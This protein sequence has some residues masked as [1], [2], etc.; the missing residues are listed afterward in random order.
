[1][2]RLWLKIAISAGLIAWFLS[3]T[4]I[5][6]VL[7]QLGNLGAGAV[8]AGAT[9]SV[10]AWLV[11]AFR[12]WL[13]VPEFQLR[14]VIRTSFI[15]LFYA[16]V[17]PGQLAGDVVKAWRLGQSQGLRGHAGA[18]TVVDRGIAM[19]TLLIIGAVAAFLVPAPQALRMAFVITSIAFGAAGC[20]LAL[21]SIRDMI[22]AR[23]QS[24]DG[25]WAT[26]IAG[27]LERLASA[28]H[29]ALRRPRRIALCFLLAPV[30]HA[31]CVSI[32]VVIGVARPHAQVALG[33]FGTDVAPDADRGRRRGARDAGLERG[34][35]DAVAPLRRVRAMEGA[36]QRQGMIHFGRRGGGLGAWPRQRG[37]HV[38]GPPVR[39]RVVGPDT[40]ERP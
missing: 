38:L 13:L 11:G 3:R 40:Q 5:N 19:L 4:A 20:L 17:L 33:E 28:I 29:D 16:T 27:A 6:D 32:H 1:M 7:V 12:L 39:V 10:A 31:L 25:P 14:E 8:Y 26:R 23:F 37:V 35:I 36:R 30:F 21:P 24:F 15:S 9:L 22:V 34:R 2:I 18:A